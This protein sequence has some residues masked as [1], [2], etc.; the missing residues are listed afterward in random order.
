VVSLLSDPDATR[1]MVKAARAISSS[2][3]IVARTRYRREAEHLQ[4]LGAAVAV[5]EEL[6]ASLEV[7]AQ[8]LGRLHVAGNTIEALLDLFRRES[9]SLRTMR[10]PRAMLNTL[11][12]ALQQ[13]PV[14]SHRVEGGQ[15]AVG[16]TVAELNLRAQAGASILAIQRGD[17][18]I[19]T[20]SSD[21][22]IE[23]GDVLYLTGEDAGVLRA[24]RRLEDGA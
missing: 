5:A 2:T 3:P 22:G 14:S 19:T 17:R 1:R 11:P 13:M 6:E 10:A 23:S 16:R 9:V 7:V 18:Y 8:L 24:R 4:A 20:P 12:E 15:W 21:E